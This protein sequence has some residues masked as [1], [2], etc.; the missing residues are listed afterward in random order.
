MEFEDLESLYSSLSLKEEEA[1]VMSM[2]KNLKMQGQNK[3][4]LCLVGKFLTNKLV[5]R[6]A[7]RATISKI[8]KTIQGWRL[9]SFKR[10]SMLFTFTINRTVCE[11]WPR[12]LGTSTTHF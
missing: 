8:W 4:A 1:V 2:D 7:F 11:F 6:E 12:A 5:N 10:T 9:K 3:V